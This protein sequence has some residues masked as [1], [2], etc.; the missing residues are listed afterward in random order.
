MTWEWQI[1]QR[2]HFGFP[3]RNAAVRLFEK[4]HPR[5]CSLDLFFWL[6]KELKERS[7]LIRD[8]SFLPSLN[9]G[10]IS[11]ML[12]DYSK[13]TKYELF[14]D[15]NSSGKESE[16]PVTYFFLRDILRM[17]DALRDHGI[18]EDIPLFE[19]RF[20]VEA[21]HNMLAGKLN[22]TEILINKEYPTNSLVDVDSPAFTIEKIKDSRSLHAEGEFMGHCIY[23]YHKEILKGNYHV[24]RVLEPQRLTVL[25]REFMNTYKLIEVR[26]KYNSEAREDVVEMILNWLNGSRIFEDEAEKRRQLEKKYQTIL[27]EDMKD[28]ASS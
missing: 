9:A 11:L 23:S 13:Y 1:Q 7:E 26:G 24:A 14:M 28:I 27:F 6:R 5:L 25:Y 2:G 21:F 17:Q 10:V 4:I 18:N 12:S 3:G 16:K 20:Q 8:L 19:R 15:I 22:D